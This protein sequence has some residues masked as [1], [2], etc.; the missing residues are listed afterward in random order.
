[1][2]S[3]STMGLKNTLWFSRFPILIAS[4]KLSLHV[5]ITQSDVLLSEMP[6]GRKDTLDWNVSWRET[7]EGVGRLKKPTHSFYFEDY[8]LTGKAFSS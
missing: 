2:L 1:M 7:R 6:N 4:S 5:T 3:F 8:K